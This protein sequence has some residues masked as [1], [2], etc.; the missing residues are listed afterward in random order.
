[1]KPYGPL[2]VEHRL[3]EK[4]ISL[5]GEELEKIKKTKKLN[6]DFIDT[7]SDFLRT[8]ADKCHHGKEEDILF[9]ELMNKKLSKEHKKILDD[10][11]EDHKLARKTIGIMLEAKEEYLKGK[12]EALDL[13]V[14]CLG[15]LVKLYPQHIKTEDQHFFIPC[16]SIAFKTKVF[17]NVSF[18]NLGLAGSLLFTDSNGNNFH[19]VSIQY[20]ER[21]ILIVSITAATSAAA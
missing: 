9:K 12:K 18:L 5:M 2:M 6:A 7:A 4:M 14:G 8:Y 19:V 20:C 15:E 11:I 10:L 1:M 21:Y 17:N 16:M 3:I 13:I